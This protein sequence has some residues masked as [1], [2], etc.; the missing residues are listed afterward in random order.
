MQNAPWSPNIISAF[1]GKTCLKAL[2]AK[3]SN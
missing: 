1:L 2:L 3:Q